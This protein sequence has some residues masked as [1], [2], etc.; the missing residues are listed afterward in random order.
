MKAKT[1]GVLLVWLVCGYA[2]AEL[3]SKFSTL[4]KPDIYNCDLLFVDDMMPYGHEHLA[5]CHYACRDTKD[6]FNY[7][8]FETSEKG[9]K[10]DLKIYRTERYDTRKES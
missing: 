5:M 8:T 1:L 10:I 2:A 7:S 4:P 6:M 9:C 3:H